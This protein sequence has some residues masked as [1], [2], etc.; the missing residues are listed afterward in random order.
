[1][2]SIAPVNG[3][4]QVISVLAVTEAGVHTPAEAA[5]LVFVIVVGIIFNGAVILVDKLVGTS[6]SPN[7][8]P[9]VGTLAHDNIADVVML[10]II[11]Q[12]G[13]AV[14]PGTVAVN[15]YS[16]VV[17]VPAVTEAGVHTPFSIV[18]F[19][20]IVGVI[21]SGA[22]GVEAKEVGTFFEPIVVPVVGTFAQV[23]LAVAEP[24]SVIV[25]A[26]EAIEPGTV[27]VID[28]VGKA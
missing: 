17:V 10:S 28:G 16:Q 23:N 14:D 19:E 7:V 21:S 26:G 4:S 20:T 3:Y 24:L 13:E 25:Q 15:G 2:L 27:T 18:I 8:A 1:L 11:V 9:V 5:K 12:A 22:V 6:L